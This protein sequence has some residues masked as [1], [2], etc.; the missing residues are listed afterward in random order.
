LQQSLIFLNKMHMR[1]TKKSFVSN[2]KHIYKA[3]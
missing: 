3:I 2:V 1:S